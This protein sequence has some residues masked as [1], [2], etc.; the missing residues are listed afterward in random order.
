MRKSMLSFALLAALAAGASAQTPQE[1][2][3]AATT[4]AD[5][6][7]AK[8]LAV[9]DGQRTYE[10]TLRPLDDI[11]ARLQLQTSMPIFLQNVSTDAKE[12][13]D[14]REAEQTLSDWQIEMGKRE[15][16]YR[17][18]KA[19][20]DTKPR[21]EGERKRF[22]EFV[23]RDYHRAGMDLPADKRERLK[24]IEKEEQ[25]L[26]TDFQTN[27]YTDE[28][29]VFL[30]PDEL[31]GVPEDILKRLKTANGLVAVT[32]DGP[33]F[34][35][36]MDYAESGDAREKVWYAYKR[37]GGKKNVEILGKL[38]ALRAEQATLLG[39]KTTVDYEA[40]PR[41]A[42]DRA[43]IAKF[44]EDLRPKVREKA[45]TDLKEF[46]AEKAAV[47]KE[48]NPTLYP[49]DQA[50]IKNLILE[51][52]YAVDS[53]KV[54]EYFPVQAVFD[55]LFQVTSNLY[56][57]EF[58]E[59]KDAKVWHPDV[60]LWDVYDK[61]SNAKLGEIY[62]DLYPREAKYNHAACWG[63]VPRKAWAD[64]TVQLPV[65]AL[66]TNFT[67]PTPEKPS[68]MTHDEVE[69]FF[70]EFGHALHNI[71]TETQL[72][73][74]SGT[75]V[76]R[77]FVEAP[78][79]MFE[80]WVWEPEVLAKFAKHYKTGQPLPA[81]TLAAMRKARSLGSGL[82]TEHQIYYGTVDQAYHVAP[83]GKIDTTQVGVDMLSEIEQYPKP[84]NT[85]FQSSFGHLI[86]YQGA[87]Y[88]YQWS[89]VYAQDMFSRFEKLGVLNPEAGAYYRKNVLAKGGSVDAIEMLR[90][91]LGRDP[92][93]GAYLKK[94]RG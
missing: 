86:G 10:N 6:A 3:K 30:R 74:F 57:I 81:E 27:I 87:Y 21:L 8:V 18:I 46:V 4:E 40:E 24:E 39:Y 49:W 70:H 72:A 71:L 48:T 91:Y 52:K 41:M 92:Q 26:G 89:L 76:E 29:T 90:A 68:L 69:T 12:R 22:L 19:Y 79:Q 23:L 66:V 47:T 28:T 94:L 38:L 37:R 44:Y 63:L 78:S 85:W 73:R 1:K 64:G 56:G 34:N 2:I 58:R 55:G 33:T 82:E 11:D 45:A 36:V 60:K 42:K 88:G 7:I 75:N 35:A 67:A 84:E 65:A 15:D 16:L 13:D 62:T 53:E 51:K 83:G 54:A 77:D 93:T 5:A 31:K 14:S 80:N 61:K 32:M 43:T 9:P 59:R 20:A 17:A 25:K 50:F